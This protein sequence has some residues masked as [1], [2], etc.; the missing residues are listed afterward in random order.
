MN[1]FWENVLQVSEG[2]REIKF[3]CKDCMKLNIHIK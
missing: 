2:L 3:I 1:D